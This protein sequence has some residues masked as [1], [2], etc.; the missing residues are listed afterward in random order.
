MAASVADG[1]LA[2]ERVLTAS[3]C[4]VIIIT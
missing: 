4:S 2:H 3:A 1:G